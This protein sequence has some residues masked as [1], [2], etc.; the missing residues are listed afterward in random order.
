MWPVVGQPQVY[1]GLQ[2]GILHA[3][4]SSTAKPDIDRVPLTGA[5]MHVPPGASRT[6][7]MQHTIE[8]LAIVSGWTGPTSALRRQKRT[9][10]HPFLIRQIVSGHACSLCPL[11]HKHKVKQDSGRAHRSFVSAAWTRCIVFVCLRATR[12]ISRQ[13]RDAA[14]PNRVT[15]SMAHLTNQTSSGWFSDVTAASRRSYSLAAVV[16]GGTGGVGLTGASSCSRRLRLRSAPVGRLIMRPEAGFSE[17]G[18]SHS[19]M[20]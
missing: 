17:S 13:R 4:S 1:Q 14:S 8:K 16:L 12:L 3:L 5:L 15:C 2:Q 19:L 6:Q 10:Y 18:T 11:S 9:N 20:A 7:D